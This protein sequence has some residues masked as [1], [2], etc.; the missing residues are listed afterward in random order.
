[1]SC[2][3]NMGFGAGLL[4]PLLCGQGSGSSYLPCDTVAEKK[5]RFLGKMARIFGQAMGLR[6]KKFNFLSKKAC[7]G[8]AI[9]VGIFLAP[10]WWNW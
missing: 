7:Q 1:M 2:P 5:G 10:K 4:Q 3:E 8:G 6:K 9:A